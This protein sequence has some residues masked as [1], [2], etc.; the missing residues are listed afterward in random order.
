MRALY[1]QHLH[2]RTHNYCFPHHI[3]KAFS[4]RMPC[5]FSHYSLSYTKFNRF[6][7]YRQSYL[8]Y[9]NQTQTYLYRRL[10]TIIPTYHSILQL[11]KMLIIPV[12]KIQTRFYTTPRPNTHTKSLM[13][14]YISSFT[15]A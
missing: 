13:F 10:C 6:I 8:I 2:T 1:I 11:L 15:F 14:N 9:I 12:F 7:K 3:T 4:S 5:A